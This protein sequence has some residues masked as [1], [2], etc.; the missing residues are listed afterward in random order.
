MITPCILSP[1]YCT[2]VEDMPI[3]FAR[4]L[5]SNPYPCCDS[6]SELAISKL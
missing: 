2:I 6:K 4:A 3:N 5:W 1:C